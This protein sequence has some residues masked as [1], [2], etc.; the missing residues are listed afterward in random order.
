MYLSNNH[1]RFFEKPKPISN[2]NKSLQGPSF[3]NGPRISLK[4]NTGTDSQNSQ[5]LLHSAKNYNHEITKYT[6]ADSKTLIFE[7]LEIILRC[8]ILYSNLPAW[9]S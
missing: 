5:D 3:V 4:Y 7:F 9:H 6:K 2:K 1:R 8:L